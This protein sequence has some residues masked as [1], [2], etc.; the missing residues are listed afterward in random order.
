MR[1]ILIW[2]LSVVWLSGYEQLFAPLPQTVLADRAKVSLGERLFHDPGLSADGTVS[3]ASCHPLD[4]YGVDRLPVSVGIGGQKGAF[5]APTVYNAAFQ[6]AQFWDGRARTLADQAIE[7]V[8]N[9][10]EMANT[11]QAVIA[12]LE[13]EK[14]YQKAFGEAYGGVLTQD[15]ITDALEQFQRTLITPNAPFDRYLRGEEQALS[16]RQKQGLALFRAR[17]CVSCHNG[18]NL[19]GN[20]YQRSGALIPMPFTQEPGAWTGRMAVTAQEAD[21]FYLKVPPLRNVAQSAPYLH[22]G[23]AATLEEVV[24]LMGW[25]QLGRK[26]PD[27]EIADLVAFLESLTGELPDAYAR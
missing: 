2:F 4:Q 10:L 13:G 7:P 25:H 14:S 17:G 26:L 3:C 21:R 5:N 18:V 20:L 24:G 8:T 15:T 23:S 19:G 6:L 22:D 9:P 1:W 11:W 12:Y 27:S 16:E